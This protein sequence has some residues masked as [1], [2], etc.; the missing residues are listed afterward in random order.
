[1][2]FTPEKYKLPDVSMQP[3]IDDDEIWDFINQAKPTAELVESIVQ[4]S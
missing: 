2:K 1:M 3:F 4:K